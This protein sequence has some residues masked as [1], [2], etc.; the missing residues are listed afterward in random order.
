MTNTTNRRAKWV[1]GTAILALAVAVVALVWTRPGYPVEAVDLTDASVWVVNREASQRKVARFNAPIEELTGGFAVPNESGAQLDVA[2]AGTNVALAL[3][4]SFRVVDLVG[5][6]LETPTP[7]PPPLTEAS[8]EPFIQVG[9]ENTL[10]MNPDATKAWVRPFHTV[11]SLDT[12]TESPDLDEGPIR[13]AITPQ[14]IVW[15]VTAKGLILRAEI[16]RGD[17]KPRVTSIGSITQPAS[18]ISA[19]TAVGER[20]YVLAGTT[21]YW[22]GGSVDLSPYGDSNSLKLQTPGSPSRAVVMAGP[23]GLVLVDNKGQ[24]NLLETG[25]QGSPAVPTAQGNC[26]HGA[27]AAGPQTG[28]NYMAV[29]DGKKVVGKALEAVA[30]GA[31]LEFRVNRKVVVLNDVADGRIWLPEQDQKVRDALNWDQIDPEPDTENPVTESTKG[32]PQLECDRLSAKPRALPDQY[33][34]RPGASL[35]LPLLSNDLATNCGALGIE[36]VEG[37]DQSQGRAE[38]VLEGRAVQFTFTAGAAEAHFSYVMSDATGQIDSAAV[39]VRLASSANQAPVAPPEGLHITMESG[40][41]ATPNVLVGY[42][43]PEGDP[44]VLASATT[45]DRSVSLGFSP[46]GVVTLKDNSGV[47][48]SV[49]VDLVVQD[50]QGAQ[51]AP[52]VL[53]I[54]VAV[55]GSVQP[56]AEPAKAE[57]TVGEVITVNL[58]DAVRT[59]H[60][61]PVGFSLEGEPEA[62]AIT[63]IDPESGILSFTASVPNTF[64]LELAIR[65]GSSPPGQMSVRIDAREASETRVVAVQ[66]T[67]YLSPNLPVVIDP[68]L[69][70]VAAD[71]MVKALQEYD[72]GSA[73]GVEVVP[74]AH[75][76]LELSATGA[77]LTGVE[78]ITYTVSA[79]GV[80]AKGTIRVVHTAVGVNQAPVVTPGRLSVRAGGV[81]TIP[82]L[83]QTFDPEGEPVGV[84]AGEEI[85][86]DPECGNVY[87]SA[88]TVRF[89]APEGGCV[90]PVAI[91]VPV[92]DA[93]GGTGLGRF[94][95]EV[96]PSQ[97]SSKPPPKPVD[98]VARVMQGEEIKIAVPLTDIDVDGDGVLLLQGLDTHPARGKVTEVGPDY[99][100]YQAGEAQELGTDQFTYAVEDWVSHRVTATVTVG[101]VAK[102]TQAAGVVARDDAAIARPLKV[103][104]LPVLLNDVDLSGRSPLTFC[105]DAELET[106]DHG[107]DVVADRQAGRLTVTLPP[108]PGTYRVTYWA[109]SESG[110]RD[111]AD[112]TLT[113]DPN[114]LAAP[115]QAKDIVS[116]P[117]DTIDKAAVD[118]NVMETASNPSGPDRDLRL[119]LPPPSQTHAQLKSATTVTVNLQQDLPTIVFYGLKNTAPDADGVASY[120]SI[121][122]PPISRPPYLRPDLKPI[123][124]AAGQEVVI[125][126][127]EHIA[128][129]QG[130]EG[131]Y[132]FQPT[133]KGHLEAAH[134]TIKSARDGEAISYTAEPNY[135]GMDRIEFWVADAQEVSQRGLKK[136]KLWLDVQVTPRGE[137]WISFTDPEL[138]VERMGGQRTIDLAS[139]VTVD[140]VKLSDSAQLQVDLG[141]L[142]SSAVK[143]RR[144][145]TK[146]T[147]EVQELA[148]GQQA[149]IPLTLSYRNQ[150]PQ[151]G[152]K[153]SLT[154]IETKQPLVKPKVPGGPVKVER[155]LSH[156]EAVLKGVVDPWA[157]EGKPAQIKQLQT[158]SPGDLTVGVVSGG[159]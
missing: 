29:C 120:G 13:A 4:S 108:S 18:D 152:W 53:Q 93:S 78:T 156:T 144:I 150:T 30:P 117:Q 145:G 27:W 3:N 1:K 118:I 98:L 70:D 60:V 100:K 74:V 89:Q 132:L 159:Q 39:T 94:V 148:V 77:V 31:E 17:F 7:Y 75:Q 113:V 104:N 149:A 68:L 84:L 85:K 125:D 140:G 102:G 5:M 137:A 110:N 112:V 82:V 123:K 142:T 59:F 38:P 46:N 32:N 151:T 37:L 79:Q 6:R 61:D 114:A 24:V 99:I 52:A 36:R 72:L 20:V 69:N 133:E 88:R 97:G 155:G 62:A 14:G 87:A 2:Q 96:H 83:D 147:V 134:G 143:A 56:V 23:R 103:L 124:V 73:T 50:S 43:D 92:A 16:S 131:A 66:D 8:P 11:A 47:P 154:V 141:A 35:V 138:Q 126:L 51:A 129:A 44:L 22:E 58:R 101:V 45:P 127:D 109:C 119:F 81:V 40:S 65:A 67:A 146:L 95:V 9:G 25:T 136:S 57:G 135:V 153:V 19:L 111:R 107:L 90:K 91:S 116:P 12:Q 115:P 55:T 34:A 128:V 63:K 15:A 28:E 41:I 71:G 48:R 76:F 33:E 21:L 80:L 54:E 139:F 158:D 10:I 106:G 64:L 86:P 121:S 26:V 130:Q 42:T 122:V 49:M 157:A 105:P